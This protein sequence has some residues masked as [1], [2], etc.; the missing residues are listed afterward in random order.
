MMKFALHV[1][2]SVLTLFVC[3]ESSVENIFYHTNDIL[4]I[5]AFVDICKNSVHDQ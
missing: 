3:L 5:S 2:S 1:D 4:V